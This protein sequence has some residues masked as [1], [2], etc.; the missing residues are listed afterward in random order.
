MT[1]RT[2]SQN[3]KRSRAKGV[4]FERWVVNELKRVGLPAERNLAQSR[5]AA[6]E[7]CDVEGSPW[8]I[9]C[10]VGANPDPRAAYAQASEDQPPWSWPT[11]GRQWS[12][13]PVVIITKRDRC[14]PMV[15]MCLSELE[16][17]HDGTTYEWTSDGPLVTLRF[18]DWLTL[19]TP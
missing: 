10:K 12:R 17:L 6:R 4:A 13:R 15:T 11:P 7:G 1:E 8:W 18:A 16:A 2:K 9:E 14:E 19:V 3:G 5:T